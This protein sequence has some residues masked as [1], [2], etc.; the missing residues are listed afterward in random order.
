MMQSNDQVVKK[1]N[2]TP[3]CMKD[4]I[5]IAG[6]KIPPGI[7]G[8]HDNKDEVIFFRRFLAY[9]FFFDSFLISLTVSFFSDA[10]QL[11]R[12]WAMKWQS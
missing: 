7:G 6:K 3:V 9:F 5:C 2:R 10:G 12:S 8:I 4:A 1:E 11:F